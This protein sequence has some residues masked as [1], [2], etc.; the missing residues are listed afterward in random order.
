MCMEFP[1]FFYEIQ[2]ML[3]IWSLVPLHFLK[4]GFTCGSSQFIYYWSL[5]EGFEHYLA[6]MW[7]ECNCTVVWTFFGIAF[8]WDWNENWL[9]QS[10]G[11]CWVFQV[12]WHTECSALTA[13]SFRIWNSSARNPSPPLALFAVM[14][15]KM[16]LTSHSRMSAS[17]IY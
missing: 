15:P 10:C 17:S 7:Y 11:H 6:S 16:H 1:C 13:S 8:F 2:W 12:C 3:A 9:F 14:L 4:P 5:I